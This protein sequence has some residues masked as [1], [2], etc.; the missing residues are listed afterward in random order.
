MAHY[1]RYL[2]ASPCDPGNCHI[3]FSVQRKGLPAAIALARETGRVL[4]L[5]PL[6]WYVDQAQLMA[7]AFLR[8]T[9][10]PRF[11]RW[12]DLFDLTHLRHHL[13]VIELQELRSSSSAPTAAAGTLII[14]AAVLDTAAAPSAS[15]AETGLNSAFAERACP[16]MAD[17]GLLANLSRA[18]PSLHYRGQLWEAPA[19]IRELRCGTLSL[20]AGGTA[21][22]EWFDQARIVAAFGVGRPGGHLNLGSDA[23]HRE[24]VE[25]MPPAR[26]APHPPVRFP[27][28]HMCRCVDRIAER[29]IPS[30]M[31]RFVDRTPRASY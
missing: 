13:P 6:E 24:M 29:L 3:Y 12:S 5:P 8:Q 27:T 15:R 21:V 19:I 30:H 25:A 31:C 23:V 16:L 18:S 7:N 10:V 4:V 11:T 20:R 28:S 2:I 17:H 1:E 14:D 22:G 26:R 9:P